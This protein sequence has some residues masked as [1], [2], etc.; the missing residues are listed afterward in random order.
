[1][2][3]PMVAPTS[4]TLFFLV[5]IC[6]AYFLPLSCNRSLRLFFTSVAK[7]ASWRHSP[8]R[9]SICFWHLAVLFRVR[10]SIAFVTG[11]RF[12][13]TTSHASHWVSLASCCRRGSLGLRPSQM[14]LRLHQLPDFCRHANLHLHWRYW[15]PSNATSRR[16]R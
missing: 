15:H 7:V 1:M 11:P 6:L 16:F 13:P 8:V 3:S 14:R 5:A 2:Y 10:R 4:P 9:C 12:P